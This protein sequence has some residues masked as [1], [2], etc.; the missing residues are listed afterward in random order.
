M[1]T[2]E[3]IDTSIPV[4]VT[5]DNFARAE[6]DTYFATFVKDAGLGKFHHRRELANIDA[7]H[8]VRENRDTL[9]SMGIFDVSASPVTITI[10]DSGG[11]FFSMQVINQDH[12][13][14]R[15]IY[16]PGSHTFTQTEIGTRYFC[17]IIRIFVDPNDTTDLTTVH[18]LQDAIRV[19]QVRSGTFEIPNWESES[20]T[21]IRNA[22]KALGA[23]GMDA[24]RAFGRKDEVDPVYHLIGT[25]AGW[26]GNP[27]RDA[28]YIGGVVPNN[29]GNTAY[30][31]TVKDVPV[32]GFWS[33]SIYNEDGFFVKNPQDA[34]TLNNVTAKPNADSSVTIQFGD[35]DG[36]VPNCLPIVPGWNYTIRL[37]RPRQ[38]I[39]DGS[40]VFP[41]AQP[42]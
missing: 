13:T 5:V 23:G 41:E 1:T 17:I 22:F 30:R 18:A 32:D 14:V 26:G 37:Y 16:T 38:A 31:L 21:R 20:L 7:Q 33:I 36:N 40:W 9:Y 8:V 15:V 28:T 39:L 12:Y 34:Y 35:C 24:S 3:K 2:V 19:E 27:K 11:R 29:D 25:A 6:S 42:V 4:P 10:P